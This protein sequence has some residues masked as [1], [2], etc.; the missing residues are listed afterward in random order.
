[1]APSHCGFPQPYTSLV[2]VERLGDQTRNQVSREGMSGRGFPR[3]YPSQC[4]VY[5][6]NEAQD[7]AA[8]PLP[9]LEAIDSLR[10]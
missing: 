6:Q 1:M 9:G 10:C 8:L 4:H 7:H 3:P 2:Q 5:G